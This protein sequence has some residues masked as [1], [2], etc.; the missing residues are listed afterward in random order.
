[1]CRFQRKHNE[2]FPGQKKI[3][4]IETVFTR[5]NMVRA[6]YWQFLTKSYPTKILNPEQQTGTFC[7]KI[8]PPYITMRRLN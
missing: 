5:S 3:I 6:N 8:K 1:M 4:N 7:H 2:V